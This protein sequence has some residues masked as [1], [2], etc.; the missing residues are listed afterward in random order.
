MEQS[1]AALTRTAVVLECI[2][3]QIEYGVISMYSETSLAYF[4]AKE[5]RAL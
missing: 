4:L 1:W 3:P 5:M 2:V